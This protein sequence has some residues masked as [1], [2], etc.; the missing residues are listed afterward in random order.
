MLRSV[1]VRRKRERAADGEL[2]I[3]ITSAYPSRK[4]RTNLPQKTRPQGVAGRYRR[5][6]NHEDA[7]ER[8]DHR[9]DCF[10]ADRPCRMQKTSI[11]RCTRSSCRETNDRHRQSAQRHSS[12]DFSPVPPRNGLD[13]LWKPHSDELE[14]KIACRESWRSPELPKNSC[15]F[16]STAS[17]N[18]MYG[19]SHTAEC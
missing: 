12:R 14:N 9:R 19:S 17:A 15:A 10:R 18:S 1:S 13:Q 5:Q 16:S 3:A 4:R 7:D 2:F 8:R 6:R 11:F